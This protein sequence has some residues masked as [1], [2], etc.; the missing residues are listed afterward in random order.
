M[1][2][3]LIKRF[4]EPDEVIEVPNQISRVVMLGET[5]VARSIAQPGWRWSKDVKPLVGTPSCRIHHQGV[6][7][8]GFM[9]ILANEGV[10]RTLGPGEAFDIQ[11]GHD[12][13]VVGDE[14]CVFIE[15]HGVRDWGKP[16]LGARVL[17]TLL[18]TDI[19]GSTA[20]ADRLG[21]TAWME[22]LARHYDRV[23]LQ[24]ERH[25]GVE[26]K[27]TGDG[28]LALFDSAA[29]AILCAAAI[30]QAARRDGLEARAGVHAGEVERYP[31]SIQGVAVHMTER[32]MSLARPGEVW[33]SA[34]TAALLE[35]SGLTFADAGEHELKG[36]AGQRRLYRLIGGLT[37]ADSEMASR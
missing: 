33:L 1:G 24:L 9:Q 22:V 11:P 30:C 10:Q 3:I 5:Y 35:G 23:R 18:L 13:W 8:S 37:A 27:T 32:I 16:R 17:T 31:D 36:L 4:D 29:R 7:L 20:H 14:P 21:D 6:I 2:N 12:G 28:F 34:P 26:S 19:V 25:Q 15:F